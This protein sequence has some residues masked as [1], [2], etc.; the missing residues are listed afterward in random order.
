MSE[1]TEPSRTT[2][3]SDRSTERSAKSDTS[4][5]RSKRTSYLSQLKSYLIE[6]LTP[7]NERYTSAQFKYFHHYKR[8]QPKLTKKMMKEGIDHVDP[9]NKDIIRIAIKLVDEEM[10]GLLTRSFVFEDN[11]LTNACKNKLEVIDSD[12]LEDL[13]YNSLPEILQ[14]IR[15]EYI[16]TINEVN[17]KLTN[18]LSYASI[19]DIKLSEMSLP[20]I[21]ASSIANS[22]DT[23]TSSDMKKKNPSRT[24]NSK[25][26]EAP[27]LKNIKIKKEWDM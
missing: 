15:D 3:T 8:Y 22:K 5:D 25:E 23:S 17:D 1:T 6:E 24:S 19:E 12:E 14:A 16:S 10:N 26:V 4:N 7:A 9:I 21:H 13:F 2:S 18:L 27:P 11:Q 20:L